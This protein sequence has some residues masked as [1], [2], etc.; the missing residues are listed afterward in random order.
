MTSVSPKTLYDLP[1]AL[2]HAWQELGAELS[3]TKIEH[4]RQCWCNNKMYVFGHDLRDLL[5]DKSYPAE[6]FPGSNKIVGNI[7]LE[8]A[9]ESLQHGWFLLGGL[10]YFLPPADYLALPVVQELLADK[11]YEL[12]R[13]WIGNTGPLNPKQQQAL[14]ECLKT[15]P[16]YTTQRL[17]FQILCRTGKEPD[18]D[19]AARDQLLKDLLPNIT[20]KTLN[21]PQHERFY[22][23]RATDVVNGLRDPELLLT[24]AERGSKALR[25]AAIIQLISH[26]ERQESSALETHLQK[27]QVLLKRY[28]KDL[29]EFV[30]AM[31]QLTACETLWAADP[32]PAIRK[33]AVHALFGMLD[34]LPAQNLLKRFAGEDP[35]A[36]QQAFWDEQEDWNSTEMTSLNDLETLWNFS[37]PELQPLFVNVLAYLIQNDRK[38]EL[39]DFYYQYDED[40]DIH[41]DPAS[42]KIWRQRLDERLG[43]LVRAVLLTS[44]QQISEIKPA[45]LAG[46][47]RYIDNDEL[48]EALSPHLMPIAAKSKPLQRVLPTGL[49]KVSP[50]TLQE[51]GWLDGKRKG[52]REVGLDALLKSPH[53]EAADYLCQ[54]QNDKK[55]SDADKE[56]IRDHLAP[57][58]AP[59][60]S[61]QSAE[62]KLDELRAKAPKAKIK[63]QV[64]K[65]WSSELDT[66]FAP[67]GADL[68]RWLLNLALE[69]K[70]GRLHSVAHTVMSAL[71]REQQAQIAEHLLALLLAQNGEKKLRWLSYFVP[72]YGDDR[73]VDPLFEAFKGWHKRAKPK[74]VF[75]IETLAALDTPYALSH[76]HEVFTKNTYSYALF[77][78][79]RDALK[80][81]AQ[82]RGIELNDLFDELTPDFGLSGGGLNLDVGPYSY[83][84][85]LATDLSLQIRNDQTGKTSKSL[86]KAKAGEDPGKRA[87]AESRFKLLRSSLK[88]AAKQQASRLKESLICARCWPVPRWRTLFMEHALLSLIGQGLLWQRLDDKGTPLGS[89]RI[90]EDLSLIDADSE[91]V[92]LAETNQIRLWHPVN[93][94]ADE[95][96]TWR[97]HIKDYELNPL[98]DQINQPC[99][100]ASKEDLKATALKPF[101]GAEV[102]QFIIKRFLEG[103]NYEIYDQDGAHI[104][105]YKRLFPLLGISVRVETQGMA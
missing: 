16:D 73:L 32:D 46:L 79:A 54:L 95:Q 50:A 9:R 90:S 26:V 22:A 83:T 17:A 15:L 78:A 4:M 81:A 104:F 31:R 98:L 13:A 12:A 76:V 59:Q 87:A 29:A 42:E 85:T 51:L 67:L 96:Q 52:V 7:L 21:F 33:H 14:A 103:W 57:S 41:D 38:T 66:L 58:D 68:G 39:G 102:E 5:R 100:Q 18:F 86:P 82:R 24:L 25:E 80:Q 53:P 88:K 99:L 1:D 30:P 43:T 70:D 10:L 28:P 77:E 23:P 97:E 36:V 27:L 62:I 72:Q 40:I 74:A 93:V 11:Q 35:T 94:S 37:L 92:T 2:I 71:P 84:V 47:A 8:N 64:V 20:K 34:K 44:P 55:T 63:P 56:R 48:A 105:G 91:P 75:A 19:I 49:S 61:A 6:Q 45:W 60:P 65:F 101:S 3:E 89:F 69:S